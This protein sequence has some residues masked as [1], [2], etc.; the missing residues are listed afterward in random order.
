MPTNRNLSKYIDHT[1]LKPTAIHADIER[2]CREAIQY[3][4]AAVCVPPYHVKKAAELLNGSQVGLA[5]VVGF[6]M[7]YVHYLHKWFEAAKAVRDGATEIDAVINIA[8]VKNGEWNYVKRELQTIADYCSQQ[9]VASK[10]ILE[11]GLLTEE[12][13]VSLCKHCAKAGVN[14]VKTSTGYAGEGQ[15]RKGGNRCANARQLAR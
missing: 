11:T 2:I 13:I 4:F 14:Y 7:G 10:I 9:K 1:I 12:E 15:G 3:E 8:A 6:P 5:T